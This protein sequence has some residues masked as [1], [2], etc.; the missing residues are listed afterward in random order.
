M[1]RSFSEDLEGGFGKPARQIG[2]A[3]NTWGVKFNGYARRLD[4]LA[5]E[6]TPDVAD[7]LRE[8][9]EEIGRFA[10]DATQP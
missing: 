7:E 2:G 5:S 1:P 8:L 6:I 9:F 3:A 4:A 10:K